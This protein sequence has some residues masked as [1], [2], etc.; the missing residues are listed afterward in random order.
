MG[1]SS[2]SL[3]ESGMSAT[4]D[5]AKVEGSVELNSSEPPY[6]NASASGGNESLPV[7]NAG[8]HEADPGVINPAFTTEEERVER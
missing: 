1:A 5:E 2:S 4:E 7:S 8:N 3:H 6:A